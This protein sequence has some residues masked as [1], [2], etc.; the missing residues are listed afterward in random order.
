MKA[1]VFVQVHCPVCKAVMTR[2][3]EDGLGDVVKCRTSGC[4][5][6]GVVFEAPAIEL[7][8]AVA[9]RQRKAGPS[10]VKQ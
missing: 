4:S 5:M 2:Y 3:T 10:E 8:E 7:R 6:R 9:K 1:T